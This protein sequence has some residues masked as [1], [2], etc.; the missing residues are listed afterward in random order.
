MGQK[1]A[2]TLLKGEGSNAMVGAN[3]VADVLHHDMTRNPVSGHKIAETFMSCGAG[4]GNTVSVA[5][6]GCGR[7]I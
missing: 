4:L 7:A 3:I 2:F 5:V 6:R 1:K